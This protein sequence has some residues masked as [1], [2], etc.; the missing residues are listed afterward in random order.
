MGRVSEVFDDA[1]IALLR[2]HVGIGM[3]GIQ[4]LTDH[5]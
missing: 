1:Q 2:G 4:P 3:S 5:A